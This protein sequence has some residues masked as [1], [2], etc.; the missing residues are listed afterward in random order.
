MGKK[1]KLDKWAREERK[2][3]RKVKIDFGKARI[4]WRWKNWEM[5]EEKLAR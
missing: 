3:S 1:E 2:K 5:I 4:D